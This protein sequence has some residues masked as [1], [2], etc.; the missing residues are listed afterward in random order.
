MLGSA[1][2]VWARADLLQVHDE[3]WTAFSGQRNANFNVACCHSSRAEVLTDHCLGPTLALKQPAIIMLAGPGL[4]TAQLLV[5]A[6]W[7]TVGA[8]PLME[9]TGP[10]RSSTGPDG[11]RLLT[12]EELP[13]AWEILGAIYGLDRA[14][15]EAAIPETALGRTDQSIWGLYADGEMVSTVTTVIEDGLVVVWAMATRPDRQGQGF[16]RRLLESVLL[17]Q[18]AEG[19]TGSLL[20]SSVAGEPLYRRLGFTVVEYLQLWS[21]PRWI[22]GAA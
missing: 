11:A 7:I 15:A 8:L 22:L 13:A 10:L 6:G 14:A 2:R 19:A 20:Q 12:V 5:D 17:A 1:S 9:L 4:A 21:R 16:G 18:F 3:W